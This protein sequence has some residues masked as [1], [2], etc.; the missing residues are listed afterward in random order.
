MK[1]RRNAH[2][3]KLSRFL[4]IP[5]LVIVDQLAKL[6]IQL[7]NPSIDIK[8]FAITLVKNTGAVW[9]S[10]KG[11]NTAFIWISIMAI[12]VLMYFYDEVPEK[13]Q[14]FLYMV[15]AGIIGN[16]I[17]RIFRG[18]VLD[19]IDFKFWPVFNFADAF[20]TIGVIGLV[21][22]LLKEK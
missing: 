20:I 4:I 21:V 18:Y 19:F 5:V 9:G 1:K 10:F 7:S 3:G 11:A 16:L 12:G 14:V 15:L 22:F 13:S 8:I 17:D 2:Y 6:I